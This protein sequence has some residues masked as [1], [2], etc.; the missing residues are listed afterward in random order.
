MYLQLYGKAIRE[1]ARK[2]GATFIDLYGGLEQFYAPIGSEYV[3]PNSALLTDNSLHFTPV[4]YLL[5]AGYSI[6]MSSVH[7]NTHL[8]GSSNS[9]AP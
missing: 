2:R 8:T 3:R 5:T 4:G 1:I 7:K 6:A 9:K